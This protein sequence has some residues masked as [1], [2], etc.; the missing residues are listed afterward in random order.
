[1]KHIQQFEAE[2]HNRKAKRA[3]K[4]EIVPM[5][6]MED[7]EN[8]LAHFIPCEYMKKISI[9]ENIEIRFSDVGHLLG[10]A[11]IE[12]W[13]EENGL[14]TKNG[15]SHKTNTCSNFKVSIRTSSR[16]MC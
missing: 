12:V 16:G 6:T 9:D 14:Q 4:E 5:Y 7:A 3:G 2:W 1:M 11:S 10:S 8:V 13:F 15:H